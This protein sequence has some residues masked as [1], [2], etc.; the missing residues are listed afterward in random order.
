MARQRLG[1]KKVD[2]LRK[3][4][5][6]DIIKVMVRGGTDHRLDLCLFNGTI[7]RLYKDGT[8]LKDSGKWYRG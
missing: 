6:L 5:G 4:T 3:Q 8:M 7:T 1:Q 2:K